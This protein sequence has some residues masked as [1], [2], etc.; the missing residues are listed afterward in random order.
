MCGIAGIIAFTEEGKKYLDRIGDAV[1][2]LRHRGPDGEGIFK[3]GNVAL[4]HTRLSIIDITDT[5][6]QPF[7]ST[8]GRY[9]IVFNGEIFNYRE[10]RIE[11]EKKGAKFRTSS[12][13]EVLLELYAREG[14]SCFE[15]LN[16][17]FAFAIYDKESG[18][19]RIARDRYGEKPLYWYYDEH[20]T[21]FA[22][23]MKA[24]YST[25]IK[26]S[27]DPDAFKAYLHLNYLPGNS[28]I[29]TNTVNHPTGFWNL[30]H[31]DYRFLEDNYYSIDQFVSKETIPNYDTAIQKV[32]TLTEKAV[33]RR[34]VSDV[35]LGSF[36]SGGLDSS[37]VA[38][39]AIRH[40][41]DL[42]TF[43]I[44]FPDEPH[45]DETSFALQVSKHIGT[46]HHVFEV[47]NKD[48]LESLHQFLKN[49]DEP[50]ADS[51][52]LAVNILA[53]ETRKQVT[54]ALS[55][56][57][58]D[59]LFAGYNKHEAEIRLQSDSK[60]RAI[61]K[62]GNPLWKMLPSSRNSFIGN[63]IR[64]LR[65]LAE[66]AELNSGDR[67]WRLAGFT[68]PEELDRL[69]PQFKTNNKLYQ[70]Y[71]LFP[72]GEYNFNQVLLKDMTMVLRGDMLVKVDRMSMLHGLEVRSPFLDHELVDYV[73]SLPADYKIQPGNRKRILKDAFRD[74][75]PA[76]IFARRKQGFEVPL[77]DWFRGE[78]RGMIDELLDEKLLRE[79]NLFN[80]EA[81][82]EIR[83]QLHSSDPG[84]SAAR[85]WGLIVFQH[86]WKKYMRV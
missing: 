61:A 16:G 42:E 45:F 54:V 4:G 36:L 41:T 76:E 8:D 46:K 35:P 83:K 47:R 64:Q 75:L 78:L 44:G 17:F 58:A 79:Q 7:T 70:L 63:K 73:M 43:S 85:I 30:I 19:V 25:G 24:L 66:A 74:I 1:A 20:V 3:E 28:T 80:P 18:A 50:F 72:E 11:L 55:G 71:H 26:A 5:A 6:S 69:I 49:L 67:Y 82:N 51:S 32:K 38:A 15:K 2:A 40:K 39:L 65:K 57:G 33:E 13:T 37:I 60:L 48:L 9:T 68:R 21:I 62:V 34:L 86:W 52:A 53:R 77:L 14:T 31:K 56:D 29:H 12:D 22:S 23:E 59:E 10:L 81:V 84:D 27:I